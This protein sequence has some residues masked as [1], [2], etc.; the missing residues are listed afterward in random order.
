VQAGFHVIGDRAVAEATTGL[1]AAAAVVGV[2]AMAAARHRLEHVEML[3]DDDI[4]TLAELGVV[5]SV[6]PAFDAAWGGDGELYEQRLGT[7]RARPMNPF[8][9][10]LQAGVTLAFGSDSPITP[11][12]P[13]GAILAAVRH[14]DAY[15]RLTATQA[16]DAHTRGGHRARRDDQAG[17][18]VAGMPATYAVWD[19]PAGLTSE[20]LPALGEAKDLPTCVETVVAGT[21]VFSR[22][23]GGEAL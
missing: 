23:Q 12:D 15:E 14:H 21:T 10:L 20:G 6:Q 7:E 16:F 5:A 9:R 4:K 19:A 18:L 2:D 11:V 17:V 3:G 1:R 22:Q 8:G 13:W